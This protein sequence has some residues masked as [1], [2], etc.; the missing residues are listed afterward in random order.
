MITVTY[1]DKPMQIDD[2]TS[3]ATFIDLINV[4]Q[5]NMAIAVNGQVVP[6]NERTSTLLNDGD[7]ILLIKAFYG[8]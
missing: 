4:G 5:S 1:N 6:K 2:N 7:S 3:V 8:G